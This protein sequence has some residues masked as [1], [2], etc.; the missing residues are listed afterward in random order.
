MKSPPANILL[1]ES[2]FVN[3]FFR[4]RGLVKN[5]RIIYNK[6]NRRNKKTIKEI[7]KIATTEKNI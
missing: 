2:T 4:E 3:Y 5:G 7:D 1:H 6:K